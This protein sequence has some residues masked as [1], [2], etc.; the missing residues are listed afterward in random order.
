MTRYHI[1]KNRN[2]NLILTIS[3]SDW[4]IPFGLDWFRMEGV[5]IDYNVSFLCLK[6]SLEQLPLYILPHVDG[7]L[8]LMKD[9][10]QGRP[11]VKIK[12]WHDEIVHIKVEYTDGEIETLGIKEH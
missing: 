7:D 12:R 10:H 1:T 2:W 9:M 8:L 6:L 11:K 4:S 5:M 3:S